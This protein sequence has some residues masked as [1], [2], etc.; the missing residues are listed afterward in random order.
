MDCDSPGSYGILQAKKL[1]WVAIP[2]FKESSWPGI[3]PR[4][5]ALQ[6][7]SLSS[8]PPGKPIG[9][10][11]HWV[12]PCY[13]ASWGHKELDTTEWAHISMSLHFHCLNAWG[14]RSW[15]Q[16]DLWAQTCQAGFY[17][18]TVKIW[19]PYKCLQSYIIYPIIITF[20]YL[21]L[22]PHLPSPLFSL[23][24]NICYSDRLAIIPPESHPCCALFWTVLFPITWATIA[25]TSL[26][27]VFNCPCVQRGHLSNPI[28]D[29][30]TRTPCP[31][32]NSFLAITLITIDISNIIRLK[33]M[34][35]HLF[36]C[37]GS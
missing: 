15:I 25:S 35:I 11:F 19:G 7:D 31:L 21:W 20:L 23:L 28:A 18:T 32:Y 17:L 37:T 27:L 26:R 6:T 34:F 16:L 29:L 10:Y 14:V 13:W 24:P 5:P 2:F 30:P 36:G 12:Y 3:K 22:L 33:N 1:E 9:F 4:S 8:E